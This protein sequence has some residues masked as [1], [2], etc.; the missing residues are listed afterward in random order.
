MLC[1]VAQNEA[2]SEEAWPRRRPRRRITALLVGCARG[3]IEL[4]PMN[5]EARRDSP[6]ALL[7]TVGVWQ[8]IKVALYATDYGNGSN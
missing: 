5:G 2:E 3:R 6:G 7:Y 1:T 4:A 8:C